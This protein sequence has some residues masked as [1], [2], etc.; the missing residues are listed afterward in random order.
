MHSTL[1]E[2]PETREVPTIPSDYTAFQDVF[3]KQ[4]ATNLPLHL[5]WYCAI[6]L[7]PGAILPKG[8]VYPLSILE[9]KV[10]ED[11]IKEALQQQFIHP[12]TP[13]VASSF[14]VGKK[15]GWD[16]RFAAMHRLLDPQWSH[17]QAPLSSSP[18]PD[19]PQ[20]TPW[21]PHLLE[22]GPA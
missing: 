18:D 1:V 4:L 10:M 6:Y 20:G 16:K 12:S 7:L 2:S 5:P 19:C 8:R 21:G 22:A 9:H 17:C 11:Y 15:N 3:S 14:F 13:P